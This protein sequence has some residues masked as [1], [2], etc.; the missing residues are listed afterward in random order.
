MRTLKVQMHISLDG[1]VSVQDASFLWDA[2]LRNY[3]IENLADVDAMLLGSRTAAELIAYWGTVAQDPSDDDHALG[4]RI[5]ELPKVVF[6]QSMT[7]SPW[8]NTTIV[9]GPLAQEIARLKQLPGNALIVYGGAG[10]VSSL[11]NEQLIDEYD[12]LVNPMAAGQGLGIFQEVSHP[13]PLSLMEA[14]PFSCGTV[15]LRYRAR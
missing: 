5:T 13:V 4:Q 8:P 1:M 2:E 15:L 11:V 3:A 9:N 6:S 10:F 12:L 14:R 7:S